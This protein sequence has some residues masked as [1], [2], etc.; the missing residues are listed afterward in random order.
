MAPSAVSPTRESNPEPL[1]TLTSKFDDTLRFYLNGTK[2]VL[3]D[4]DPEVTVLEYLRG[5]GL[6]GTKLGCGEG[7]CGACTI[8]VSQYNPTTKKI[9]HASV[10][11]CLAPLVSL[12]GKH[13]VT[14]EGIGSS[15]KPH[16]TQERIAKSNGSQCGFCTPGIVMSLYALLRNNDSP[17]KDDV[18]EA[19][20]GN[21]CRCTGYRSILDAA[22]TFSVE[23]PGMKFKKAGGTGCCM[24]NG[25]G[26]PSGGC[27]MDK[28]NLDDAPIK[29]FTPPGFIEYNPDT[30]LIFPP[31]LK[32]HELRPLAFG[33][34]RRRWYRPV[35]VEQLLRIKSAHPQAK[36]IGGSTETQIET[37]FK[38]LQYPVSV[39]V[40]DI[41]ELR[42]YTFK[43][44]HLEVGGNVVLT[45]LESICEHAIPHYGWERAQ[46]FEAMLKQLKFFAGR[47]IR[48]VGTPAGNLVTASP[49][50]DLNPVFW[51]ANAVL[52]AKSSTK[53]TEIPVSQFFTG[54][55]KTAL[56]Q[57]AIIASI[58]IP[59]TQSK[60]EYFR[61]YKQAK[62]K[63][64][65]IAIVTGALRVRLDDAGIVQE[66]ALIYGGMAAMTA[67]AKTAMEYLVG[68]RFSDLETLEGTMNALGRDFDLQFSVPGG[69]ASYRKSL[70]FGF[71]YRFYHDV[72]TILDG[73]SEQVDKEAIDEIERDLSSGAVDEDAAVAYKKE[74][75]GKS[76]PHLAALKQT[77]GE[78]QYTDDIPAMKNELHAC[79][80]L[81]KR[82]HAKIISID[83]SAALDIPG[84]VDVVD[85]DDMPS[86]DANKFGAP[87]FDE[88]FFAEGKVLTVG[89]P[90]ALVLATS[91]LRAQE[92]ARAVK[93]EYEDL[94]SVLSIEDAIAADSYHNFYREI[95]KGDTEK[96]FK[97][98]DHV[99]TGTV[100]MGG[101]EHFYLETN[102][103]LVVPKPEDGEMEIFASTQNANET[104]VFA[105][106]VCDVQSNKVVVRVKRL[107]GGFGGKESRSV[108]LSSILALAAKKTKRPVRYML[109]RE[110]D[111]VTSGQRHP[112]LGKYKIGVNKDG[113]IQALDCDVFNNAGWTFDLS[114]AV[115]ER[116][117]THI[118]GCYD[119]PNVYIRG[120]LCKTNTMSNTAFRG[121][122]GPQGMFIAESYME[123]VADRLG[124][125]VE[126]LRQINLYEKDGQTHF[127]QGLGDWHVP[128]MYKQVQEEAMYE[129]RRHAITD[130]NQTNKW[131][132]R[133]LALIP[134]K[135]GIS[136]TA[137]FL[138]Q[139]GALVHIYHDGSVLVAHGGTEMG[140]GLHTKLTQIAAQ[141]LGVPLDNVFISE[142]S[143]NTVANASATAASASSDLNGYAIFNACE[144]LNERLAPYRKKLGPEATMKD[145]AHAAY[146]DRVNLSA[147]GFYKTPEIGYDWNTGKGKMFFYF[148]QGVAAAEVELDLLTGT[149]TC[150]RADIKMDVGQSINPAIDYGQIQGAFIQ[151][152]GLFTMEESL[153][154]RNGPMAGH[155]FTRGPGAYKI[156]G[157]RDIPQTFNV[158]LLKDVEW[159][160]L[161]TIQRSRGVGEPPF[162]MGSSVF[163]AIRDALK[164]ARAQ[165]G[166]KATIGDDSCEGLL[167]LES[168]ATPERI[169]LACEDEIMRKA[170]VL[171][172][173]GERS[174]FVAI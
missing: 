153:W 7:G 43:E 144:Q 102:A 157:F 118:D 65:D 47:Q 146:F 42:Q 155:L 23:K 56:A 129:A 52:V 70:A 37:K 10:N 4:I 15:Q 117:M 98:C 103:C 46:V 101:Q 134:T 104:Q 60:G 131:R 76:N 90:I 84:V 26:P 14:V 106:R 25:N 145:L 147:Q 28:A 166:V 1:A 158:S 69:M 74:V 53:E 8:V 125:P 143:T 92:A 151:G 41:A 50:S 154:L 91:P 87:H 163:F 148:T 58:R 123:E 88:V 160:E 13:V 167:R 96:A 168:P 133:G 164:A 120:R 112:F 21:L 19:F 62:R 20:D 109:S 142:T 75:T 12:D 67:A 114:A 2:V 170:R 79:Y 94:P 3:D 73:S 110:E 159:K 40:G 33:N 119:I 138:N 24:E 135:F 36:I 72:L 156:P 11:A 16:P 45:D 89:Q 18:E 44:D 85:K 124:M 173:E 35:T 81:S 66:A 57:D 165:S 132:K 55:R 17:S 71:F 107:G 80:V 77:T 171:P 9:Y 51:A 136:F 34:K 39:Y 59:V 31:A 126:A 97:E 29:R 174:F 162:F 122:G 152:L 68:R 30:E 116:A 113:K 61:A 161:R 63:D 83:Y 6:T 108:I 99:F 100:R 130:F 139:A 22:Q 78:A 115:C 128:L 105:S 49:I 93:V 48:N 150:I 86:P 172:K 32:R 121:F 169:R 38:A 137:L 111:M 27:C 149:W 82:A 141:T 140:Q 127:G 5:I 54:Y 64:D 95:K